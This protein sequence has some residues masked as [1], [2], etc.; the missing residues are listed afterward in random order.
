MVRF[1][2]CVYIQAISEALAIYERTLLR[3]KAQENC[4]RVFGVVVHCRLALVPRERYQ[5]NEA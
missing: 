1:E 4:A 2:K 3:K 5:G